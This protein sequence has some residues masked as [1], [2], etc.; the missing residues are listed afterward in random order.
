MMITLLI[1][2]FIFI[3]VVVVVVVFQALGLL[4]CSGFRNYFSET[5]ESIWTV[6]RTPWTGDRPDA[7]PLPTHRAAQHRK[8][9]THIHASSGVRTHDPSVRAAEDST[10]LRPRGHWDQQMFIL[11]YVNEL[12]SPFANNTRSAYIKRII[13]FLPKTKPCLKILKY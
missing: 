9:R 2:T 13:T 11:I 10:C 1:E 8:T 4:D 12:C 3:I 7:K 6:G 5:Y